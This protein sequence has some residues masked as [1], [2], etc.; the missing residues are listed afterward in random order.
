MRLGEG[1]SISIQGALRVETYAKDGKNRVSL[2]VVADYVT[3]LHQPKHQKA[4]MPS[5]ASQR[6]TVPEFDAAIPL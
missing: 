5:R 4:A 6:P 3:A 1:D 2:G